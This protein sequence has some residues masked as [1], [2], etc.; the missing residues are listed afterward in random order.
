MET[1]IL[2]METLTG[3]IKSSMSKGAAPKLDSLPIFR[4]ILGVTGFSNQIFVLKSD[5]LMR[6]HLK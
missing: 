6:S 4:Q 5:A 2:K 3:G 1:G